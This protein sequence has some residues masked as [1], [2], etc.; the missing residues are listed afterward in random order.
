MFVKTY[1]FMLIALFFVSFGVMS[2]QP[3]IEIIGGD[4][5]DW[6]KVKPKDSPLK[7]KVLV[8]NTG[9]EDL[10]I[11]NVKP[12]CGCTAAPID[13]NILKPNE[14]A[15]I[16]LSFNVGNNPGVNSKTL[17]IT[18][19]D[20][21]NG[22]KIFRLQAE[23]VKPVTFSP[24]QYFTFANLK[25]GTE[26]TSTLTIENISGKEIKI[27]D[28]DINP[29]DLKIN[30]KDGKVLKA[31]EKFDLTAKITPDKAGY[32]NCTVN[33]KTNH[34]DQ[35]EISVTGY[36]KVEESAVFNNK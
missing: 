4:K 29:K 34:P 30:L 9:N 35:P 22:T 31:G 27:S 7:T 8:K 24:S 11:L 20:P 17:T 14:T 15:T 10:K 18:S 25:V 26:A 1:K 3:K 16:D 21:S 2:A 36:G 33:M 6:G 32:L 12:S 19:N 23:L 28:I 5:Y 13:K